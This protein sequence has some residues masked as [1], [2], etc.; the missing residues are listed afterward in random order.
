ML[1]SGVIN[2]LHWHNCMVLHLFVWKLMRFSL[3]SFLNKGLLNRELC[4]VL[5]IFLQISDI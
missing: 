1:N 5:E 2:D 3:I 4:R